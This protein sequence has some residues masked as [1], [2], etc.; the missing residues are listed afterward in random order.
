MIEPEAF[1]KPRDHMTAGLLPMKH[2]N[3]SHCHL[4][5]HNHQSLNSAIKAQLP[6]SKLNNNNMRLQ[7]Y[8]QGGWSIISSIYIKRCIQLTGNEESLFVNSMD[9]ILKLADGYT[10]K[11]TLVNGNL[12]YCANRIKSPATMYKRRQLLLALKSHKKAKQSKWWK[13]SQVK[14]KVLLRYNGN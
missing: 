9:Y 4:V 13:F 11:A 8:A 6:K 5:V 10:K 1:L 2:S 14:E 7:K 12:F 3:A